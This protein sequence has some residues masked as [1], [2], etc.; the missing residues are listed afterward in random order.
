MPEPFLD[1]PDVHPSLQQVRR[2]GMPEG[3][4][5]HPFVQPRHCHRLRQAAAQPRFVQMMPPHN[6][7]PRVRALMITGKNPE[8]FPLLPGTWKSHPHALRRFPRRPGPPV[9]LPQLLCII[10]L[11]LQT[12]PRPPGK[13]QTAR[14]NSENPGFSFTPVDYRDILPFIPAGKHPVGPHEFCTKEIG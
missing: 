5:R 13:F 8:P 11:T 14:A 2:I 1:A 6:P 3:V 9:R 12:M 7:R 10:E 4:R